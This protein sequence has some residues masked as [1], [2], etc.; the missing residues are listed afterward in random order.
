MYYENKKNLKSIKYKKFNCSPFF[1]GVKLDENEK[2]IKLNQSVM[3]YNYNFNDGS[4]KDGLGINLAPIRYTPNNRDDEKVLYPPEGEEFDTFWL[5]NYWYGIGL[6]NIILLAYTKS[7]NFYYHILHNEGTDFIKCGSMNFQERPMV[8]STIIDDKDYIL[9]FSRKDGMY[10]WNLL[11]TEGEKVESSESIRSVCYIYNKL[12]ILTY[13]KRDTI[14]YSDSANPA[15]FSS[16][17]DMVKSIV[18]EDGLGQ[19]KKLVSFKGCLYA[20]REFN[21]VKINYDF[22]KDIFK[23]TQIFA[24]NSFIYDNTIAVCGDKIIYLAIDG[25]YVFDGVKCK[26]LNMSFDKLLNVKANNYAIGGFVEGEYY[27]A[28]SLDFDDGEIMGSE[29]QYISKNNSLIKI[30]VESKKYTILRGVDVL[31]MSILNDRFD[32]NVILSCVTTWDKDTTIFG[33][34]DMSGTINGNPTRKVWKTP[35][36]DFGDCFNYK[37]IK[38]MTIESLADCELKINYDNKEKIIYIKGKSE[39]QKIPLYLK[40]KRVS[41]TFVSNVNNVEIINPILNVG[42]VK[43][44]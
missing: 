33:T 37:I 38:D 25:L 19:I 23:T 22:E 6:V 8:V 11:K 40:A 1:E 14:Y 7:G 41:L 15:D 36:Y 31:S 5:F 43:N 29:A 28:C 44:E 2:I 42:F 18:F 20:F 17:S 13:N 10:K 21:I 30:N 16:G 24:G 26:K 35:M 34:L 39:V 27:L 4:L 12:F 9:F 3:S 32:T